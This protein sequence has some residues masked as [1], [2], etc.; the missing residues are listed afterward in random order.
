MESIRSRKKFEKEKIK[1][2]I[3]K[4]TTKNKIKRGFTLHFSKEN[5]EDS[6]R[7]SAS[8]PDLVNKLLIEQRSKSGFSTPK[9]FLNTNEKIR[10]SQPALSSP[11][12]STEASERRN[13]ENKY[14][15]HSENSKKNILNKDS[16]EDFPKRKT[17][18]S[19]GSLCFKKKISA[20]CGAET[21]KNSPVFNNS[22]KE[23][24]FAI[25]EE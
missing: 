18:E 13:T 25:K 3:I 5:F 2:R 11:R 4:N 8:T 12:A 15:Q 9:L 21:R 17:L 10:A 19:K 24:K 14:R 20:S 1:S 7:I 16:Y 6:K 22:A 23:I